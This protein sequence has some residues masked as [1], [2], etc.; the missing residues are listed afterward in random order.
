MHVAQQRIR[1]QADKHWSKRTFQIDDWVFLKL[2]PNQQISVSKTHCPKL[3]PR[4]YGPF[5]VIV[6][7]GP[8][9]YTL[10]LHPQSRIYP[11]LHVSLLKPKLGAH[12]VA[13]ATLPL[14]SS[15][16][17]FLWFPEQILQCG[18]FKHANKAVTR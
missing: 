10:D 17:S 11:T 1:Q 2:H 4:Y 6:R 13:S 8:V 16:G 15:D 14:V 12:K 9:T 3:A 18:M 5:R 7:V